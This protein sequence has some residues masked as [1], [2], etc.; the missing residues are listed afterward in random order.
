[1]SFK[2][3]KDG[4]VCPVTTFEQDTQEDKLRQRLQLVKAREKRKK[5][6][7]GGLVV[8]VPRKRIP[9]KIE[10]HGTVDFLGIFSVA[11]EEADTKPPAKQVCDNPFHDSDDEGKKPPAKKRKKLGKKK[12]YS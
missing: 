2:G 5:Q 6:E 3:G 8:K 11:Y 12:N 10:Q 9:C 1:M 4:V 7:Q